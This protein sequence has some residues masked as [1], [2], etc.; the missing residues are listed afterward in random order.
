[1]LSLCNYIPLLLILVLLLVFVMFSKNINMNNMNLLLIV[2][3]L[4]ALAVY[5][6]IVN[7]QNNLMSREGFVNNESGYSGLNDI[8]GKCDALDVGK[9]TTDL[10]LKMAGLSLPYAQ[11]S[12]DH[13]ILN[14]DK[15]VY[16]SPNGIPYNLCGD[17]FATTNYPTV[18]GK[19]GMGAPQRMFM[20]AFNES[21][22]D[23]CPGT[24]SNSRGCV[25]LTNDQRNFINTRGG[26]K[27][28]N[29]NPDF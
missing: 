12:N 2:L 19:K 3:V 17:K 8:M 26:N 27:T 24:F 9:I 29:G 11:D 10:P 28:T 5:I 16:H 1:M 20:M 23:C 25:C 18:D 22:P 14:K 7:N 4:V 21:K 13:E 6:Y 15:V